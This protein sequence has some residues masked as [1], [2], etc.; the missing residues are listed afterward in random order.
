MHSSTFVE[1]SERALQDLA[2]M[3]VEAEEMTT[4]RASRLFHQWYKKCVGVARRRHRSQ[5]QNLS[6]FNP[7]SHLRFANIAPFTSCEIYFAL[8]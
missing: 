2:V 6:L 5:L 4:E 1:D 7:H 3:L 8:F